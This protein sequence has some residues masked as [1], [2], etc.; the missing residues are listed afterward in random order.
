MKV[1]ELAKRLE[2]DSREIQAKAQ[3]LGISV[4]T[5][6]ST[7]SPE[8]VKALLGYLQ[9][10]LPEVEGKVPEPDEGKSSPKQ[11]KPAQSKKP[12]AKRGGQVRKLHRKEQERRIQ[13]GR[14][15]KRKRRSGKIGSRVAK[16]FSVR[17]T[18]TGSTQDAQ[19]KAVEEVHAGT[20]F[21]DLSSLLGV[22]MVT[23]WYGVYG[24]EAPPMGETDGDVMPSKKELGELLA[25]LGR[26]EI[27]VLDARTDEVQIE[28]KEEGVLRTP[29]ITVMGHVDHGKTTLLDKIR[30]TNV[31]DG[32][33]GAITQA[34]GASVSKIEGRKLTF[35]DTP[36]H[37]AFTAMRARG[38]Q[39]TDIVVLVVSADEGPRDQTVEA[40]EHIKASG[41]E[42]VV[43]LNKIDL[44][45]AN[46]DRVKERL[47]KMGIEP[48]DWGGD[49]PCF[50]LSAKT[51]DGVDDLL[52]GL[53]D[54]ADVMELRAVESGPPR[55]IVIESHIQEG[56]RTA[57]IL[58]TEG[59]LKKRDILLF[60]K[61][62]GVVRTLLSP[63][64]SP[65]DE[66]K[67]GLPAVVTG[68]DFLPSPG[69]RFVKVPSKKRVRKILKERE[70]KG[71]GPAGHKEMDAASLFG[72]GPEEEFRIL[73]KAGSHGALEAVRTQL[74]ALSGEELDLLIV[75]T[76]VG[77]V[78]EGD[79]T[80]AHSAGA[81]IV[82]F[83]VGISGAGGKSA[84]SKEVGVDVY[85]LIYKLVEE[86]RERILTT[87]SP[88][89]EEIETAR[90]EVLGIFRKTARLTIAGGKVLSGTLLR[91]SRCRLIRQGE[92]L[93]E[94]RID[95]LRR[96]KE[97]VKTV[98]EGFE[99][100]FRLV[101]TPGVKVG[102]ELIAFD[103][104][105]TQ[106]S[107]KEVFGD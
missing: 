12:V 48:E 82:G 19:L 49:T 93:F 56:G 99:C 44:P 50:P 45:R 16:S 102:D 69:E 1:F 77:D 96:F 91:G 14:K 7:L 80:L 70:R 32:E 89:E 62:V 33:A 29:V 55:G 36:G 86:V 63:D 4:P 11:P 65:Q 41:V 58:V 9:R 72:E 26:D 88:E 40:Y 84:R 83:E 20:T 25:T 8:D 37:H 43:A 52:K 27:R 38:A 81:R 35:L 106:R 64:G 22:P 53:L 90:L 30:S 5:N 2:M 54:L 105:K 60:D 61:A 75:G 79:V 42:M 104:K 17:L 28:S 76:G 71:G 87:L 97:D 39:A 73:L 23:L 18:E 51:G 21:K 98:K 31:A 15:P 10:T 59:T 47:Q 46:V 78:T 3:D 24:K 67:P 92:I 107:A 66:V 34:I 103:L 101:G 68:L 57:A 74:E 85:N 100:G 94:G 6:L 95:N 13:M